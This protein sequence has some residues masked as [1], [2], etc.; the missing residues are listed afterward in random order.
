MTYRTLPPAPGSR[1]ERRLRV[2]ARLR[3]YR[4]VGT[5]IVVGAL[6]ATTFASAGA[7]NI[8]DAWLDRT[9]AVAEVPVAEITAGSADVEVQ[10]VTTQNEIANGVVQQSDPQAKAGSQRVVQAGSP[11]VELVSYTVTKVNGVEVG[12]FPGISV[13]LTPP[14][15]EIVAVGSLTIPAAT[16]V[17]KG[18]NRAL[19]QQM[20]ADLYGWTGDQWSCL[21]N[22][23]AR[24]SGWS[25]TAENRSSGA[26]GI[27][28]ALP[29]SKMAIYG[30]DWQTNPATQI[31][32]G[33]A[34]IQG[35]Y[36]T[37]CGA[38]G[39]FTATNWY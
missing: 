37:P 36:G 34:Y 33:L 30:A 9:I 16:A 18:T 1:R 31:K 35:R 13:L 28:Q 24:E 38:W 15:D 2:R 21:D 4:Q 10:T 19:G 11:G 29:G 8:A 32:W 12:R 20:A 7:A 27:P 23:F 39:H 26:Y 22:L 6:A 14:T 5:T 17:Q 3:T 25:H